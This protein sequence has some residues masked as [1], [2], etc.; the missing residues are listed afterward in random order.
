MAGLDDLLS[1]AR[2]KLPLLNQTSTL[3]PFTTAPA[4]PVSSP[5]SVP[6]LPPP[7]NPIPVIPPP[8]VPP[9]PQGQPLDALRQSSQN[10][11]TGL[12]LAP[13][14]Q[15]PID[16]SHR[17]IEP[18]LNRGQGGWGSPQGDVAAAVADNIARQRGVE[19]FSGS[20]EG[21]PARGAGSRVLN[22]ARTQ[23]GVPYVFGDLD[24]AGG[25][26]AGIDCSGLTKWAFGRLGLELPHSAAQQSQM[27]PHVGRAQMKPGD[28]VFFSYGRLGSGVADHVGIYEGNGQMIAASSSAGNVIDSQPIDW[29]NF[30]YGG[31]TPFSGG[32]PG[33][34]AG[35]PSATSP[36]SPSAPPRQR[37]R[38]GSPQQR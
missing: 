7:P 15:T 12:S 1:T 36:R 23:V 32:N 26:S 17:S 27:F 14:T 25:G 34:G 35:G 31:S 22:L 20:Y 16:F 29:D 21:P 18:I 13:S 37:V 11:M 38:R 4:Q 28:L 10:Q 9:V 8:S 2:Q 19:P 24:P 6:A 3:S 30:I 33:R 5:E